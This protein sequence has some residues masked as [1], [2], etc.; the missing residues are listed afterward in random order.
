MIIILKY[1][2]IFK[3][4]KTYH[5]FMGEGLEKGW[6]DNEPIKN[7]ITKELDIAKPVESSTNIQVAKTWETVVT[8]KAT[9]VKSDVISSEEANLAI[10][11]TDLSSKSVVS[12]VT[13][14]SDPNVNS[15]V[16]SKQSSEWIFNSWP[17]IASGGQEVVAEADSKLSMLKAEVQK[18]A[19]AQV[20]V[21]VPAWW[22]VPVWLTDWS[23]TISSPKVDPV[24]SEILWQIMADAPW[25]E[26]PLEVAPAQQTVTVIE[27]IKEE[28]V[29]VDININKISFKWTRFEK[30][31][32]VL[33]N[34]LNY[35]YNDPNWKQLL[36]EISKVM[37]NPSK[38]EELIISWILNNY[39]ALFDKKNIEEG[40]AYWDSTQETRELK[41]KMKIAQEIIEKSPDITNNKM[42]ETRVTK[43][44]KT[45][46]WQTRLYQKLNTINPQTLAAQTLLWK[47]SKWFESKIVEY[48]K[49]V[50]LEKL[51]EIYNKTQNSSDKEDVFNNEIDNLINSEVLTEL[52]KFKPRNW[53]TGK[54]E[55][56]K[57]L[58]IKQK[59]MIAQTYFK[60]STFFVSSFIQDT[61]KWKDYFNGLK[62]TNENETV[63]N[64]I[65]N[66]DFNYFSVRLNQELAW[67][68]K[69]KSSLQLKEEFVQD[70]WLALLWLVIKSK[71]NATSLRTPWITTWSWLYEKKLEFKKWITW[72]LEE[73][74][75]LW[76]ERFNFFWIKNI[77]DIVVFWSDVIIKWERFWEQK[78]IKIKKE[79]FINWIQNLVLL[80]S[81]KFASKD[82]IDEFDMKKSS[83]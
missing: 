59:K 57:D 44:T 30:R 20:S 33:K 48:Y 43:T 23:T 64:L 75:F 26:I 68:M 36:K 80:G 27:E 17:N 25:Q 58:I 34:N 6:R 7:N 79:D 69:K 15:Q 49:T 2:N 19:E 70:A 45:V 78:E 77:E 28:K 74:L 16:I 9:I 22:I 14:V 83:S 46:Y 67:V 13:V 47:M 35:I 76:W 81:S 50:S 66:A 3:N 55:E 53:K 71:E 63:T 41:E 40:K 24:Q 73:W 5:L 1:V 54:Y 31:E 12:S 32:D 62:D 4:F 37:D 60:Q 11:N 52:I 29:I 39:K 8:E 51:L 10:W 18:T 61:Q 42:I 65:R 38:E 56:F 72:K 82:W 21:I